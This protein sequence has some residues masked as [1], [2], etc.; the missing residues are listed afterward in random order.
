M[1]IYSRQDKRLKDKNVGIYIIEKRIKYKK[2]L[3]GG[4]K[5]S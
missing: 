1:V 2:K 4:F 5:K 3:I